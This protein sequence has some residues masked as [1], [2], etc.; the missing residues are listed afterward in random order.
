MSC[1]ALSLSC[2]VL[3][4]LALSS[5][6]LPHLALPLSCPCLCLAA[7]KRSHAFTC[8]A[9]SLLA[10]PHL[11]LSC[12]AL[13]C[14]ALPCLALPCLALPCLAFVVPFC[15]CLV[16]CRR[17]ASYT[18]PMKRPIGFQPPFWWTFFSCYPFFVEGQRPIFKSNTRFLVLVFL[19]VLSCLVFCRVVMCLCLLPHVFFVIIVSCTVLSMSMSCIFVFVGQSSQERYRSFRLSWP[20]AC[21]IG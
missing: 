14:L 5:L 20:L 6:V 8:H 16:S 4:C 3:T 13:P 17:F 1:L 7:F 21:L 18:Q 9:F 19:C 2:L 15:L 12:L 10:L 11:Y